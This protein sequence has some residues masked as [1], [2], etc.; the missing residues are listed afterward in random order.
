[1][2]L[3]ANFEIPEGFINLCKINDLKEGSGKR[4]FANDTE[5]AVF[6][7]NNVVYALSNICPHQHAAV[8]YDGAVEGDFVLCPVHGWKFNLSTGKQPAG[9]RGVDS[10]EVIISGDDVFVKVLKK[11]LKW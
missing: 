3:P 6:K 2:Q 9:N 4:F 5:V 11:E 10:F 7:V 8:I 1:M